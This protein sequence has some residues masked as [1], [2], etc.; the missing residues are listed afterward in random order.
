MYIDTSNYNLLEKEGEKE[1]RKYLLVCRNMVPLWKYAMA[2]SRS[3][4]MAADR[5]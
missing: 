4:S 2:R 1:E 5:C 3:V